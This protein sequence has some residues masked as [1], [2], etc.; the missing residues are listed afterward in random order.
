MPRQ[1]EK[2]GRVEL[3]ARTVRRRRRKEN[4]LV[5]TP[6]AAALEATTCENKFSPL[7]HFGGLL[8]R[9]FS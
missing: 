8:F 1:A 3:W 5:A 9:H 4:G 2:E 7:M 6:P